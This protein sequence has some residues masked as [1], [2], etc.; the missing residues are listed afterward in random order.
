MVLNSSQIRENIEKDKPTWIGA[1]LLATFSVLAQYNF[2]IMSYGLILAV[3]YGGACLVFK[4][5]LVFN[6]SILIFIL[7]CIISQLIIYLYTGTFVKNQNTYLFMF[8]CMFLLATLGFIDKESFFKVYYIIGVFFS[9]LVIFQFILGNFFGI[10]QSAIRILPVASQDMHFW[11]QNTT[12]A[13]GVFT[14]PQAYSSYILPLLILL[15]FRRKFKSAIYISIAIFASTSSQGIIIALIIWAY[16]LIIYEKNGAKKFFRF[17]A[18]I[19]AIIFAVLILRDIPAVKPIIDK[20]FSINLS[21]YDIRLTKGF[22]IYYTMPILDKIIGIGFG[23]L[24][25]YLL[26]G[27]FNFF[28]MALTRDELLGYITTMSNIL[29]SFGILAFVFYMNIYVKNWKSGTPE[30]RLILIIIFV[31]SFTQTILFNAWYIFYWVVYEVM[32][33]YDSKRYFY[34]RFR[35]K[36]YG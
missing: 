14:E 10:P 30:A 27:N 31:S 4:R 29:V 20:I 9:A 15:L 26:S 22:Q 36:Y 1:V 11:I 12:R 17:F 5:V 13:S 7:W 25:D 18:G 33:K 19:V 8:I 23:N 34:V 6:K 16:Y 35:G 2:S 32:D 28:W 3:I 24:H 21:G